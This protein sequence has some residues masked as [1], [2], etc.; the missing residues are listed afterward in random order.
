MSFGGLTS[1][2]EATTVRTRCFW[3]VRGWPLTCDEQTSLGLNFSPSRTPGRD[4]PQG[5]FLNA[6]AA[7][8]YNTGVLHAASEAWLLARILLRFVAVAV[9]AWV[10]AI[11]I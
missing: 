3:S 5:A 8:R 6:G 1:S 10:A 11:A 4:G 2:S 9:L 7:D